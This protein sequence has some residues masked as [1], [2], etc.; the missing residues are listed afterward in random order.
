M[1]S[2]LLPPEAVTLPRMFPPMAT[3][4]RALPALIPLVALGCQ[5]RW[6]GAPRVP[7]PV[8]LGP[9]DRI[10]GHRAAGGSAVGAVDDEVSA[11]VSASTSQ[12]RQGNYIVRT[13]VVSAN[14]DGSAKWSPAILKATSGDKDV[15]VRVKGV[16]AGSYVFFTPTLLMMEKWIRLR[17]DAVRPSSRP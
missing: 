3:I 8:Q 6:A 12:Q 4:A 11:F 14:F 2:N 7:N 17:G 5:P 15:D 9:V 10:G 16:E 13:T 1:K